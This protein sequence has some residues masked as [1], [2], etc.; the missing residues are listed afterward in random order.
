MMQVL[1]WAGEH[2]ILSFLFVVIFTG[3]V[4]KVFQALTGT[5]SHVE[6]DCDHDDCDDEDE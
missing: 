2:P 1:N 3:M 5:P 6:C 4:V